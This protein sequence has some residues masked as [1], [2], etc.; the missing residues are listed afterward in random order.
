ML[1][2]LRCVLPL[3][4][5]CVLALV[6]S[7]VQ[8]QTILGQL[9]EAETDR[10]IELGLVILI[11]ETGDSVASTLTDRNGRFSVSSSEPG[12]FTL[13]ASALGYRQARVGVFDLGTDGEM[14]IEFR[15]R[16]EPLPIDELVVRFSRNILEHP[17]VSNGF[18][19]RLE[20]GFGHF[21]TPYDIQNAPARATTDLFRGIAGVIVHAPHI[22]DIAIADSIG[23]GG[24]ITSYVGDQIRLQ[25]AAGSCTPAVFVDGIKIRYAWDMSIEALVS[26][27]SLDAVEIYRRPS[28]VPVQFGVTQVQDAGL[29]RGEQVLGACGVIVFWT[30]RR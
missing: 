16:A 18:V 25:G 23:D 8:A 24:G 6:A 13:L 2:G 15:V 5:A 20:R 10:S 26:R 14:T 17:L 30:K 11:S 29:G 19:D 28:E 7:P 27:E 21:I 4:A 22:R 1:R 3:A 9:L 12:S